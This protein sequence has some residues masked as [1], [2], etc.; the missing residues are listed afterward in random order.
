MSAALEIIA[1]DGLPIGVLALGEVS[2]DEGQPAFGEQRPYV[3][4][5]TGTTIFDKLAVAITG[6]GADYIA[7]AIDDDGAPGIWADPGRSIVPQPNVLR[8][9]ELARFWAQ[10]RFGPADLEDAYEFELR[11]TAESISQ[12]TGIARP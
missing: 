7:L 8:P 10:A 4:R 6:P 1:E 2:A 12:N 11:I 3:L 5:N 9:G